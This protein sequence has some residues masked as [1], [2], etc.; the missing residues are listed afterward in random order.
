MELQIIGTHPGFR[1][2]LLLKLMRTWLLSFDVQ[3]YR[4]IK[5]RITLTDLE[6][7]KKP[8]LWPGSSNIIHPQ[9]A[10]RIGCAFAVGI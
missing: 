7:I 2:R 6:K 10:F 8:G 5:V 3:Y 4:R 9:E 1:R